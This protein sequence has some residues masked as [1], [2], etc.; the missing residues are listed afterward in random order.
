MTDTSF[1]LKNK[2]II[3]TGGFGF[4]GTQITKALLREKANVYIIDIKK[5]KKINKT[6]YF[7]TDITNEM[8]LKKILNFFKSKKKRIDVLINNA[9]IDY[10]PSKKGNDN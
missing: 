10:N 2:N 3:I 5:P 9:A 8:E 6:R 7:E 4:L 1:N